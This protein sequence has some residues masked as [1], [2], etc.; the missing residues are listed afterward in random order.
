MAGIL[1]ALILIAS[2]APAQALLATDETRDPV[3]VL[4]PA[5]V[6]GPR[7]PVPRPNPVRESDRR[8]RR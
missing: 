4:T 1:A 3:P 7:T 6:F 5:Q 2:L 8:E